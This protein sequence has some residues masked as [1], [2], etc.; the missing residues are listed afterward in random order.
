MDGTDDSDI[1]ADVFERAEAGTA[2]EPQQRWVNLPPAGML[3]LED[4]DA[5]LRWREASLV[6]VVGER[7]GGKTTLITELYERFLRGPFGGHDFAHSLSLL[8]FERKSFQSR[9][10]SG[11]EIPDTPRTSKQDG[12]SFFH[13]ALADAAESRRT[14]LLVSERAGEVYR[15]VRDRPA[16]APDLIEVRKARIVSFVVDG[17]RVADHRRRAE[18]LASV[19]NIARAFADS[20]AIPAAAELQIVTTKCDL[21]RNE[22]GEAARAALAHFEERFAAQYSG[23]F[24]SVSTHRTA[25]RDPSGIVEAGEGLEPLLRSWLIPRARAAPVP[26]PMPELAD[27][28]DRLLLRRVA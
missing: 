23:R 20:G 1:D 10:E 7:N 27:E 26:P 3:S 15:E 25:A 5:L 17:E 22:A 11:E 24:A 18:A 16:G 8:G 28:F 21:L 6:A 14:D 9:A 2:P 4:A 13:L 19:R 12:L